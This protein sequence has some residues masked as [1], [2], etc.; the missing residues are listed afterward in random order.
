[1]EPRYR[2]VFT[3]RLVQGM[4]PG[5]VVA[6]LSERFQ[7]KELTARKIIQGGRRYVLKHSLDPD[8]AWRYQ[9]ALGGIGLVTELEPVGSEG[10]SN[11]GGEISIVG[12]FSTIASDPTRPTVTPE[13]PLPIPGSTE[14]PKCGAM[15]IS[16]LT[17]VCDACGV[18]A[19]RYLAR[20]AAEG[21]AG[22]DADEDAGPNDPVPPSTAEPTPPLDAD[23]GPPAPRAVPAGRGWTWFTD[24]WDQLMAQPWAW[25]WTLFVLLL[26]SLALSLAPMIGWLAL[27]ILGPMLTGSLMFGAHVQWNG[28]RFEITHLI[29]GLS[30]K[31][32][33]L[34]LVGVAYLGLSLLLNFLLSFALLASVS[35]L[36]PDLDGL[37]LESQALGLPEVGRIEP[38]L[39]LPTLVGLLLSVPLMMAVLF[40][41]ALATIDKLAVGPALRLSLVGCWRNLAPLTVSSLIA[42]LLGVLTVL[43][44]GL[45]LLVVMPLLTL[46]LYHAYRDIYRG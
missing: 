6:A 41:P 12:P 5:E 20:L 26:V 39:L 25:I 43:T 4:D 14:C 42:L 24:A 13:P 32:G 10:N 19:E 28:G 46:A 45:A 18:V 22:T 7:V 40:A 11:V 44:L 2:I 36:T 8:Y 37:A 3:G 30:R 34:A 9:T 33:G 38:W 23:D 15:A 31:P 27:G 16:P 17:G 35:A 1:M 21:R 29:A